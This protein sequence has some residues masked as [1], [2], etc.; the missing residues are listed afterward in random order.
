MLYRATQFCVILMAKLTI[1]EAL[2]EGANFGYLIL[3]LAA[4]LAL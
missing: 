2:L 3:Q 1:G 4:L